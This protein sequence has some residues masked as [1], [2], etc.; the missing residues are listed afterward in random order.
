MHE[1]PPFA[2]SFYTDKV[3][4]KTTLSWRKKKK[5]KKK[6]KKAH[7][8]YLL[9]QI[10]PVLGLAHV[11]HGP[12]HLCV[13]CLLPKVPHRLLH[14]HLLSAAHHHLGS[15]SCQLPRNAEADACMR[16]GVRPT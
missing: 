12:L 16:R 15:I 14:I 9:H 2:E 6:E 7:I 11:T 13:W 5:K 1:P 4:S 3:K 10:H 8:T